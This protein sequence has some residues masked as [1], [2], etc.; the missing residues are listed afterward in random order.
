MPG[1][2]LAP[3]WT[4][5]SALGAT[6][7][8]PWHTFVR[9]TE[10]RFRPSRPMRHAPAVTQAQSRVGH[11]PAGGATIWREAGA[12]RIPTI[13]LG[14]FVPDSGEQIFLLR[15]FLLRSGDVYC[16]NYPRESFS[17]ELLCAQLT[18]LVDELGRKGTPPVILG[19]SFGAGLV[20]EWLR[21]A[22]GAATEALLT[23]VIL[24]SPV[25]CVADILTGEDAKPA[26]L[27]G[28][29]L[30]PYLGSVAASAAAI[31]KSRAIFVRMFESGAQNRRAL[32]LLM[33]PAEVERLRDRVLGTIR[34]I[35]DEGAR[36]RV[37]ALREM[38]PPTAYFQ[39]RLLPLASAPAL[40]L[41][42]EREDGVLDP[43]SP[44][45]FAFEHG[46]RA[47]F[48]Q[49]RVQCVRSRLPGS[50]VQH[51]SLIFHVFEFLPPLQR[52]YQRARAGALPLAA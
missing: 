33:S 37:A 4:F 41:F 39:P 14:G 38:Q 12:G 43:G 2:N 8:R 51:A 20:L 30:R 6:P 48:P 40:V 1:F 45:R 25:T 11:A 16:L 34:G 24:V 22:R 3:A 29:A 13:V 36:Q 32:R 9:T 35:T 47:F 49:G 46:C 31:E 28:R 50:P 10:E 17:L 23:G 44:A 15:R 19:V 7:L 27:L 18:D 52:F 5:L 21:R 26:T 42:A